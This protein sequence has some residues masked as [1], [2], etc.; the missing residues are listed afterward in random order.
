VRSPLAALLVTSCLVPA[1]PASAGFQPGGATPGACAGSAFADAVGSPAADFVAAGAAQRLYGLTGNDWIGGSAERPSCLF[2]GQ[3]DDMLALGAGGGVAFGELGADVLA[4][5]DGDDALSGGEG[6]DVMDGRGGG[7]VI[8]GGPGLD[9]LRGGAGDDVLD[10]ADG[11]GELV[12]CG[13]G[14]DTALADAVDVVVSCER[15]RQSGPRLRLKRLLRERG[16]P[17]T[18]FRMRFVVPADAGPGGYR[19]LVAGRCDRELREAALLPAA[20][21]RVRAGQVT[22]LGLRPPAGGW[23]QGAYGGTIVR[24]LPCPQGR[25]CPV[26]RPPEPIALLAFEV[27]GSGG[28]GR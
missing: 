27:R 8:R 19:V 7:D 1:V 12:D 3:G 15:G 14:A 4:G 23:C 9:A 10:S 18:I 21:A 22:R 13:D 16:G 20:G 5:S 2:G 25:T 24:T 6:P 28:G 11:R 17:R 26:A